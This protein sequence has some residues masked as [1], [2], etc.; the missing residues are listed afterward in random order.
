L[1][2]LFPRSDTS[3]LF[4]NETADSTFADGWC[5]WAVDCLIIKVIQA[6]VIEGGTT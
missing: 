5:E 4:I 1:M 3:E 2:R 6:K